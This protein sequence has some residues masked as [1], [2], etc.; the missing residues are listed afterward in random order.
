MIMFYILDKLRNLDKAMK[1]YGF[2]I[3]DNL[4]F[5]IPRVP[6]QA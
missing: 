4:K 2:I 6:V 1:V 5:C 3:F